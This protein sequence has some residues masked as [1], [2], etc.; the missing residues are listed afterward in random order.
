[1]IKV[2]ENF[3]DAFVNIKKKRDRRQ[4]NNSVKA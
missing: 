4:L 3:T 2:G 1:M